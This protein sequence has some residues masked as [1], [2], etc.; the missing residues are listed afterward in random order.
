ML[1]NKKMKLRGFKKNKKEHPNLVVFQ[2]KE[3]LIEVF[4]GVKEM[5]KMKIKSSKEWLKSMY[6]Q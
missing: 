2:L 4:K 3:K 6:K 1:Y 5:K